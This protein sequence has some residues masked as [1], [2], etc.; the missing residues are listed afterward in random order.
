MT[1]DS[2]FHSSGLDASI[3]PY[4]SGFSGMYI[5]F[6]LYIVLFEHLFFT[7]IAQVQPP[8]SGSTSCFPAKT[9]SLGTSVYNFVINFSTETCC[10]FTLCTQVTRWKASSLMF[11]AHSRTDPM[12][13]YKICTEVKKQTRTDKNQEQICSF[14]SSTSLIRAIGREEVTWVLEDAKHGRKEGSIWEMKNP[15]AYT[16]SVTCIATH[17]SLL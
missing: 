17:H 3:S 10:W 8:S 5:C 1:F 13:W 15:Q 6:A 16:V 12:K 7:S 2:L 4:H 9:S 11:T 14:T